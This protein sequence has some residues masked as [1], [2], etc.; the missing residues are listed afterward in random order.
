MLYHLRVFVN[1]VMSLSFSKVKAENFLTRWATEGLC[2][3]ELAIIFR[4]FSERDKKEMKNRK[5]KS[6]IMTYTAHRLR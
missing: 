5:R 2:S 4:L 1:T 6:C 3:T